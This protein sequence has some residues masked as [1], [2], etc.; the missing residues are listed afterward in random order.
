MSCDLVP[1]LQPH[2]DVTSW[3]RPS[4]ASRGHS[5]AAPVRGEKSGFGTGDSSRLRG[6]GTGHE[7]QESVEA[8]LSQ[9]ESLEKKI[10]GEF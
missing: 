7:S 8:E 5:H 3:A 1:S 9:K 6:N 2:H 4:A 10:T